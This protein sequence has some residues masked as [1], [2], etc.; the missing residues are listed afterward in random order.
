MKL[1]KWDQSKVRCCWAGEWQLELLWLLLLLL[2]W[3]SQPN[4][5]CVHL[6]N[7]DIGT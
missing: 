5:S 3:L 7:A 1:I 2:P 6:L 4:A